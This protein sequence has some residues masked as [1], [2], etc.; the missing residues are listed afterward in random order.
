MRV[1]CDLILGEEESGCSSDSWG[2]AGLEK[3][4]VSEFETTPGVLKLS[5]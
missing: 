3:A 4:V 1:N 5:C 2:G